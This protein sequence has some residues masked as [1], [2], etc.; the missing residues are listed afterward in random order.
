MIEASIACGA[1]KS[2]NA[3]SWGKS[4]EDLHGNPPKDS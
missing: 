2:V 1:W 3:S 4:H